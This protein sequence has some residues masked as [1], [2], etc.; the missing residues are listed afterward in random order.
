MV[1]GRY[2]IEFAFIKV[3]QYFTSLQPFEQ[4]WLWKNQNKQYSSYKMCIK[5]QFW[6]IESH[7]YWNGC[8]SSN[9]RFKYSLLSI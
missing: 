5:R 4:L 9:I 1:N 7:N 8:E 2:F 3:R 6:F